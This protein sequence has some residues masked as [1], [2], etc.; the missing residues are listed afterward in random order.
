M[1]TT[2]KTFSVKNGLSVANTVI[3]DTNRNLSNI[4]TIN[5]NTFYSNSGINVIAQAA[6]AYEKANAPITIKE[7][8]AGNNAVVN[9]FSNIN[10]IQFDADSGMAVVDES[11]NTV[12]IQLNSTFKNW[13]M[14]GSP[15]LTAQGL[16]T[17]NFVG[18][19]GILDGVPLIV[20]VAPSPISFIAL[21]RTIYDVP[22]VRPFIIIGLD[23]PPTDIPPGLE[24]SL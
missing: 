6:N 12:T 3:I 4:A 21:K 1:T 15:G 11:N 17:V 19:N 2:N 7:V 20:D 8:Y 23:V 16:D 14:N 24:V 9:T 10:T 22:F 13:Q 18:A 5:A